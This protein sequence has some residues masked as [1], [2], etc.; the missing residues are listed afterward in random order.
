MNFNRLIE[1]VRNILLAPN[2]EWPVIASESTTTSQMYT[3][4]ILI[5]AA[6]PALAG[7]IKGSI[8]GFGM[9]FVGTVRLGFGTGITQML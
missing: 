5:L 1:R 7:F 3:N 9:P 2:T 8:L 6:I 4:Y